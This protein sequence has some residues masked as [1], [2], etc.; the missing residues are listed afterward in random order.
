MRDTR[1]EGNERGKRMA[2]AKAVIASA[3]DPSVIAGA[4]KNTEAN[5]RKLMMVDTDD[6]E[7][8]ADDNNAREF[9]PVAT[10]YAMLKAS[11]V[12]AGKIFGKVGMIYEC[13]ALR[14]GSKAGKWKVERGN[15]RVRIGKQLNENATKETRMLI[16]AIVEVGSTDEGSILIRQIA[17]N[18]RT[19]VSTIDKAMSAKR[20]LA[21][22]DGSTPERKAKTND[23]IGRVLGVSGEMVSQYLSVAVNLSRA[24]LKQVHQNGLSWKDAL[25]LSK[26]RDKEKRQKAIDAAKK[27][28]A[29]AAAKK[30]KE[31]EAAAAAKGKTLEGDAKK[32][33]EKIAEKAGK[34]A[35]STVIADAAKSD[36]D[37]REDAGEKIG[38][39]KPKKT[40]AKKSDAGASAAGSGKYK[41]S[42]R[43]MLDGMF[44]E[45]GG[46]AHGKFPNELTKALGRYIAYGD[47]DNFAEELKDMHANIKSGKL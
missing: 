4:L 30:A 43:D 12:D 8:S 23:E 6:I 47:V 46:E 25:G 33:A 3:V 37:M 40:D 18:V 5:V 44:S 32:D 34:K 36:R 13:V 15:Q 21:W 19:A 41:L 17:E 42:S 45:F 10:D 22:F 38:G 2:K 35:A 20:L 7:Y 16:P 29:E 26:T 1:S 24:E 31:L 9:E 39:K 28:K 14:P 27:A 11:I